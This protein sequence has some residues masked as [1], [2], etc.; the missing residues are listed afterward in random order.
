MLPSESHPTSIHNYL[1][2]ECVNMVKKRLNREFACDIFDNYFEIIDHLMI[3]RNNKHYIR[4]PSVKLEVA[5]RGFYF[6]RGTLYNS[7]F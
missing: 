3:T 1:K 5:R 4:L 2:R 6:T 7:L